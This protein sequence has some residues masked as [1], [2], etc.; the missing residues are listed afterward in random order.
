[1]K[2]RKVDLS[3]V[4]INYRLPTDRQMDLQGVLEEEVLAVRIE[5]ESGNLHDPNAIKVVLVEEP[6]AEFH[7]GYLRRSIAEV[8]APLMDG[9]DLTVKEAWLVALD[10][11][12][13]VGEL[14]VTLRTKTSLKAAS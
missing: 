2:T 12:H 7:L 8:Y 11:D 9:G 4:G 13:G 10:P 1:M 5:R 3:V 14:E 6:Y